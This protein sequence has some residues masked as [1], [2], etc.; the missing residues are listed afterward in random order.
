MVG[1]NG[2]PDIFVAKYSGTSGAYLWANILIGFATDVG[3]GVAVDA[4]GNVIVVGS[5]QMYAM[6]ATG[7]ILLTSAGGSDIFIVKYSA[8][9]V[10]QWI[11]GLGGPS[12]DIAYGVAVDSA[13][14]IVVTGAFA[15]TV[16]FGGGPLTS[17]GSYDLFL[18][19]YSPTGAHLWSKSLGSTDLDTAYAVAVDRSVGSNGLPVDNI[20][21]AGAF[22]G[23]S[24]FGGAPL[25]SAG[26]RDI[27]VAKYS[28]A[29]THLW[30]KSFGSTADD[31]AYGVAVDASGNAFV[32]GYFQGTVDFSSGLGGGTLTSA[33]VVD[34][35]LLSLAP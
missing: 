8:T 26:L 18:A 2:N 5:F 6:D 12:E 31:I 13:G 33:G 34:V 23:T 27:L 14:N 7:N 28:S 15:G 4:N 20:V 1:A 30:S 11:K 29:G 9:G 35:F 21:I 10:R 32:T 22:Q 24:S 16:D 19:K 25:T 3:R 17:A